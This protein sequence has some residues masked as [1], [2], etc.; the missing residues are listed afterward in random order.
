MEGEEMNKT[1]IAYFSASGVTQSVANRL[2]EITNGDLLEIEPKE[3]YTDA[4]LDWTNNNSRSYVEMH[5]D[6]SRPEI[7]NGTINLENY[8]K[9]LLGYPIWWGEAPTIINTFIEENNFDGKDIYVFA[10]SGGSGVDNS[11]NKL[12]EQYPN[13]NFI[14]AKR[15]PIVLNETEIKSW[16]A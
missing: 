3:K 11:F 14:S 8:D 16:I 12:K 1:L 6:N 15:L 9:V 4:D 2:K 5:S 7:I 13:L 10:T